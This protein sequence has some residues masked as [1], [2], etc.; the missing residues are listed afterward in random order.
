MPSVRIVARVEAGPVLT[1]A[2]PF[3]GWASGHYWNGLMAPDFWKVLGPLVKVWAI[4]VMGRPDK[5]EFGNDMRIACDSM[6]SIFL[7]GLIT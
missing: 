4:A 6:Y 5:R 7:C 1:I 3:V 2:L